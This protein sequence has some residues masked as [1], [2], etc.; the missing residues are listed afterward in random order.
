MFVPENRCEK[1]WIAMGDKPSSKTKAETKAERLRW[2]SH[3]VIHLRKDWCDKTS[4]GETLFAIH[5]GV[6]HKTIDRWTH[7]PPSKA[8]GDAVDRFCRALNIATASMWEPVLRPRNADENELSAELR[9]TIES[10]ISSKPTED[11]LRA[12]IRIAS[13]LRRS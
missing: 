4:K 8:T 7:T 13:A 11:D 6:D 1:Y 10:L 2:F 12:V 5:V 9:N 3:H